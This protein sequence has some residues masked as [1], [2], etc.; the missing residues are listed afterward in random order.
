MKIIN[1]TQECIDK[2]AKGKW[3]GRG[4]PVFLAIN[5]EGLRYHVTRNALVD[6]DKVW[7]NRRVEI[8]LPASAV[9]FISR[10]DDGLAVRSFTFELDV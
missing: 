1:V 6:P 10:F 2:G 4:C 8:P 5:A 9:D 3:N 7:E